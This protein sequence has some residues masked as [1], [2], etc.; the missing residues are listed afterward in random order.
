MQAC[1]QSLAFPEITYR[2]QEADRAYSHTCE[3]V[4]RHE[5][6]TAWIGKERELLWIKGKPGAG[7][8]TLMAF[9]YRALQENTFSKQGLSLDFF[10]H[11]RGTALQK[12]PIGMFRSLIHQLYTKVSLV[13]L[14]IRAAF[15]EKRGFGEA[16]TGWEW[17]RKEL[18]DL[19]SNAVIHA[20]KLRTITIFVDALDEA[21]GEVAR[22]LAVYYHNLNDRL[23][24]ERGTARICISCRHYPILATNTSLQ[25]CVEDDNHDDIVEYV[26]HM[27]NTGISKWEMATLSIDEC[28]ALEKTIVERALGVFQWARLVVP[29]IIDL[30]RQGESLAYIY[31]ELSKVPQEL[32]DVYEHILMRVIEPRNRTRT[33]HL[34]QWI[35]LA[36]RPLSVTELRFA[37]ASDDVY[38]H[39]SRQLCK[40]AQDFVD[41]DIRMERLITSL[42][43]G[44]VE[45][46]HH[47]AKS[48][49][50][51]IHQ[52]V[53]DFLRSDGLKY[54][55]T[56][57]PSDIPSQD[58]GGLTTWS[59]E[60]VIGQSQHRLCKSCV[61]YLRLEEVLLAGSALWSTPSIHRT[62]SSSWHR[63]RK[64]KASLLLETLPFIDYATR[65]W[66]F[67]AEKAE[68]LGILQQD[69]VQQLESPPG[70]AFQTW[71]KTF[72]NIDKYNAKCP[73]L[74]STLLHVASSS[75]LRSVVQDLLS[76]TAKIDER[77]D[78]G[79]RALHYAAR[80][81]HKDLVK[82]LLDFGTDVGAT[83][84][85]QSTAL[86]RAAANGHKEVL[87]ILLGQGADINQSTGVS[88][89][90]LSAAA[91]K[92]Y[93]VLVQILLN[94][95]ADVNTQG[96]EYGTALQAASYSGHSAIVT[97]LLEKG[98]DV[99][100]QGGEYGTALQ[101][102]SY[103]GHAA[104][105]T[106]LL[107][108]GADINAQGGQY[109]T[110]LQAASYRGQAA[111][112]TLLLEKGAD[113]N[114]Q[115]GEYN[116]ALQAASVRGQAAIVM[117]LVKKGAD[118][119]VQ[120]G[121]YNTALQAASVGGDA[122]IITLL[123]EEGADVNAR[124]GEFGTALQAA[125][126][127]GD[128]AIVTLLLEKGADVNAQGGEY[129]TALQAASVGGDTPIVTLLLE[130]GADVNAQGGEYGTALQAA[131]ARGDT[132]IVTLLLEKGA[133]VNVQGGEYGTALQ[134]AS[135]GGHA[136]HAAIVTLLLEKGALRASYILPCV[137]AVPTP[138]P[139]GGT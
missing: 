127:G 74:G 80:W 44:L 2:R 131:S 110:A 68:S 4:L 128:T 118:V 82:M 11:G 69:L 30:T 51:F 60:V 46:K 121:K 135:V 98:A 70:L 18:E 22:E 41:T 101:A 43:G 100:M 32:G 76:S 54:L 99:N 27:L 33:L 92:G 5:S 64:K 120:G 86:E 40:D 84:K 34:M 139:G 113:V 29:L 81:G 115:G 20:A 85:T 126:A 16:G 122:G 134:A 58:H 10:F 66:F 25:I 61:N 78:S 133:D 67:H 91:S 129:G 59:A 114:T 14:S 112:V 130:K 3:W 52:S 8:S 97:L 28:Q 117:L 79:N 96:G 116:T 65:Y 89:N 137:T 55:A 123:L 53:N 107:E 119:N 105:V 9:I 125:S 72:H 62:Q 24:A 45:V 136:G 87:K 106:L 88:G 12:T 132:A 95:G 38:I 36:E 21:G 73:E 19:F 39:K 102:A 23:A 77:D 56:P 13:R 108:K 104:I 6:Y 109:G 57:S 31:Q 50:Q 90:A 138:A 124:G 48:T 71:I 15:R 103:S 42:S 7:K 83:T 49:V 47:H 93:K 37:I 26:N 94:E 111:I 17:Q 1:L 35:C 63:G 75:N